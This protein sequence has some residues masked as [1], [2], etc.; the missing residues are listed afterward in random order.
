MTKDRDY[1]QQVRERAAKTGQSY[2]STRRTMSGTQADQ[3]AP[4]GEAEV[5]KMFQIA[6][7]RLVA[8]CWIRAG[9]VNCWDQATVLRDGVVVAEA[10]ISS[11]RTFLK[12]VRTVSAGQDCGIYLVDVEVRE[13]DVF[14]IQAT[15]R[16]L[17]TEE[18]V[19][20]AVLDATSEVTGQ[21]RETLVGP[22]RSRSAVLARRQAMY[23]LDTVG[24]ER[25]AI[26]ERFERPIAAV[27]QA[28]EELEV[29]RR[30]QPELGSQL[31]DILKRFTAAAAQTG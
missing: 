31:S 12:Q 8:G 24:L 30:Q 14:L 13:G 28:V 16:T 7:G 19:F 22:S 1:K 26:A 23:A 4:S 20:D 29:L 21:G 11:I 15:G 17:A 3:P 10:P 27:H 6:D 25:S 5:R 9:E 18:R 2:Q